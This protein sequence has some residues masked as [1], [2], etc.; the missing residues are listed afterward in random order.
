MFSPAPGPASESTSH[1]VSAVE[2]AGPEI[3]VADP[4]QSDAHA[5][6]PVP[7]PV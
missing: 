5:T 7:T 3:T 6:L 4:C 2:T 1:S